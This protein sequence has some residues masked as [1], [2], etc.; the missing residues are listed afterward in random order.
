MVHQPASAALSRFRVL[1]LTRVRSGPTAV[2]QL[3]DWGADVVKIEP[4]ESLQADGALGAR[5][6]SADFKNIQR[7]KR[8]M[9]LNLKEADGV[10]VLKRLVTGADVVVENYRPAVK[11]RLGINYESLAADNP[12]LVYASISG[13]G[14]EGPYREHPAF[15][16]IAQGLGGL[17]SVTGLKGQ[18]PVRVG[19]PIADLSAGLF[20]AYG[21]LVALLEREVSGRGQ[22]VQTSLLESQIFMLDFQ[23]ARWLVDGEVP[24]QAG[25]DHPTSI[26]TGLFTTRDGH[27]NIAVS[28]DGIW[29]QFCAALGAEHLADDP[30]YATGEDRSRNREALNAEI[31]RRLETRDSR[32]WIDHFMAAGVPS[33][34]VNSIDG[35][36]AD[37]QVRH[38]AIAQS[39]EEAESLTL[40][41]QPVTLTRT[42][43][44]LR[45][46]A[47]ARGQH[48]DDVLG[49]AGYS[50]S[51]IA[52]LRR[53][54]VV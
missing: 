43:S 38:T 52:D 33:G 23:A 44:R 2:R 3:A 26:P 47:P 46:A 53:R 18:G 7:N 49:E 13:F 28:G 10:A 5:R 31:A 36:F 1:D 19:I 8:A 27:I 9:T 50:A 12:R 35:T 17:M 30:D 6:S 15:D 37:P 16:Q 54:N 41:G 20:C 40:V 4:P 14:Q 34:A 51:E 22:W 45:V 25:N 42:P 39:V 48:T 29:R 11:H 21:I 24:A 32:A